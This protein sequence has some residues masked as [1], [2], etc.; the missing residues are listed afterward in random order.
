MQTIE[1]ELPWVQPLPS[2][3]DHLFLGGL[4]CLFPA[5][6]LTGVQNVRGG[7]GLQEDTL[8]VRSLPA[9]AAADVELSNS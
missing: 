4:K 2:V 6:V 5:S 9:V 3:K 1:R 7:G 8:R